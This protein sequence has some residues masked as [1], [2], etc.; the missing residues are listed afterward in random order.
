M[1]AVEPDEVGP[2]DVL[3]GYEASRSLLEEDDLL[4]AAR[5]DRLDEPAARCELLGEGRRYQRESCGDED[6][7][8]ATSGKRSTL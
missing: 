7:V 2:C 1:G 8:S 4:L 3:A 5:A 6:P